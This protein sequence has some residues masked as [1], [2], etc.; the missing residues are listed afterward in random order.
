MNTT[1]IILFFIFVI[2]A[3]HFVCIRNSF[4]HKHPILPEKKIKSNQTKLPCSREE[5]FQILLDNLPVCILAKDV[6]DNFKHILWNKELE[7]HTGITEDMILGKSD[8]DIEPWPGLGD[9]ITQ[10]DVEAIRKGRVLQESP[11]QSASGKEIYYK[12]DKRFISF[13]DG[14]SIILDMYL[15]LTAEWEL[16][17]RL[18]ETVEKQDRLI[19]KTELLFDCL[20]Y[21]SKTT[22]R[23]DVYRYILKRF[24]EGENALR[25]YIYLFNK[26]SP[27]QIDFAYEW[28]SDL[29]K[30]IPD[31][32]KSIDLIHLQNSQKYLLNNKNVSLIDTKTIFPDSIFHQWIDEEQIGFV[33]FVPLFYKEEVFGLVGV[34]Y[35]ERQKVFADISLPVINSAA[36]LIEL[37]HAHEEMERENKN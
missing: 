15:D 13:P 37:V 31:Y 5:L 30:P 32:L 7:R 19:S 24:G 22:I 17:K 10:L 28:T 9:Y 21:L 27:T 26:P 8:S 4:L 2:V 33:I 1:M 20:D 3:L 34:D 6:N 35:R 23:S 14:R 25:S 36:R 11:Y 29:S 12:I 18:A 16:K